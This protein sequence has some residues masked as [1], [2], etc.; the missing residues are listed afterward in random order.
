M[1]LIVG[2]LPQEQFLVRKNCIVIGVLGQQPLAFLH[3]SNFLC[4]KEAMKLLLFVGFVGFID[5]VSRLGRLDWT[6]VKKLPDDFD[7]CCYSFLIKT[8]LVFLYQFKVRSMNLL[9]TYNCLS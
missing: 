2:S 7:D 5:K 6:T 1:L 4:S 9:L 3:S 8:L